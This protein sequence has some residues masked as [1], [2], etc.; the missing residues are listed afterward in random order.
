MDLRELIQFLPALESP[1]FKAGEM[2]GMDQVE[3]GVWSMP[4]ANYGA[5]ATAFAD[6]AYKHD[7]VIIGFEWSEWMRTEEAI[8][9]RDDGDKLA[10]ASAEQLARLLTVVIRQDRFVEGALLEAFESGLL[11]RVARRAAALL[12]AME[13]Q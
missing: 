8:G 10:A 5:V 13:G 4:Y 11:L 1:D 12:E 2:A 9:L 3:P 6:A 7:W